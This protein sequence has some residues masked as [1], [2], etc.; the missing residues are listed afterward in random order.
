MRGWGLERPGDGVTTL[1]YKGILVDFFG[2]GVNTDTLRLHTLIG[3][4]E[5]TL[6]LPACVI[7]HAHLPTAATGWM[8][9]GNMGGLGSEM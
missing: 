7:A 3:G 9:R 1:F 8:R 2:G 4:N 6:T 5:A